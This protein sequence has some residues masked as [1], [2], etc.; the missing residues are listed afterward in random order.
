MFPRRAAIGYH[1]RGWVYS[2]FP[3][4]CSRLTSSPF[5]N[6]GHY[7]ALLWDE[8]TNVWKTDEGMGI[9]VNVEVS[10]TPTT[11]STTSRRLE[12]RVHQADNLARSSRAATPWSTPADPPKG[13]LH[14]PHKIQVSDS[15]LPPDSPPDL[16]LTFHLALQPPPPQSEKSTC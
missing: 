8:A 14:S 10:Q 9:H 12:S 11:P 13:D 1:C 16:R 6:P 15:F 3:V 2:P 4:R 7:R 5:G